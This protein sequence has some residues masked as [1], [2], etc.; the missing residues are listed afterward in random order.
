[1]RAFDRADQEKAATLEFGERR[2]F[3]RLRTGI[4]AGGIQ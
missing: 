4:Q 3:I 2:F 1:L